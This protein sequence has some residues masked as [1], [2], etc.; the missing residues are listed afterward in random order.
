LFPHWPRGA[1]TPSRPHH[2]HYEIFDVGDADQV[3]ARCEELCADLAYGA[4]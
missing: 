3:L 4:P 2:Q 1:A